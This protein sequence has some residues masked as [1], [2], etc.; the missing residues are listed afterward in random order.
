MPA[1]TREQLLNNDFTAAERI[2]QT[3][4][5]AQEVEQAANET[6]YNF[7]GV[8]KPQNDGDTYSVAYSQFVVPLVKAMQEQQKQLEELKK[9]ME[10]QQ[11]LIEQLMKK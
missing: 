10:E 1:E 7:N 11:K 4:F 8:L 5:I 3:G 6:N 2:R 9:K